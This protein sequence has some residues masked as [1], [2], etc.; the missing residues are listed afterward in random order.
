MPNRVASA[1]LLLSLFAGCN[2]E[3]DWLPFMTGVDKWRGLWRTPTDEHAPTGSLNQAQNVALERS[4]VLQ[5]RRGFDWMSFTQGLGGTINTLQFYQGSLIAHYGTNSIARWTGSAWSTYSGTYDPPDVGGRA[6]F[7]EAED[8]LF[9]LSSLGMY[10]LDTPTGT[11]RLTGMPEGLQGVATLRR[12]SNESG[13][14]TSANGQW[15]YRIVWGH[16][17]ANRRLQLGPPSGRFVL[18]VPANVTATTG[19]ISKTSG[20]AVVTVI[21]TT[22]GF[23]TGEYVDVT[24]GGA[25]T[26]FAAGR[27]S[28]TVVSATSFTYNDG[29]ASGFSGNPVNSITYGFSSR[30][31]DIA[32]PI[33]SGV[34]VDDFVQ[35]YRSAKSAD[36]NSEPSDNLA[37]V[38]EGSPTN[39]EIA[40]GTMTVTDRAYDELR[41]PVLYTS[42]GKLTDAKYRPPKARDAVLFR[43][44]VLM[45]NVA[46][47]R[48][49]ELRLLTAGAALSFQIADQ[50]IFADHPDDLTS[51]TWSVPIA[52]ASTED[53]AAGEFKVYSTGSVAQNI[54]D[55]AKSIVRAINGSTTNDELYAAYVSTD[56]EAP[57]RI[58][59]Y[60][61][62]P[63]IGPFCAF[64]I[65]GGGVQV[66]DTLA[67]RVSSVVLMSN[68]ARSGSTVTV[69][70]AGDHYFAVGQQIELARSSNTTNF[71]NGLKTV[72]T[73]PSSTQFT[74]T[75][76]GVTVGAAANTG[77]FFDQ[78]P[79][80]FQSNESDASAGF[81][82]GDPDEPWSVPPTQFKDL[83]IGTI[84][85]AHATRDYVLVMTD[86]GWHRLLGDGI[87]WSVDEYDLQLNLKAAKTAVAG[88]RGI[89]AL[90]NQGVV[91]AGDSARLISKPIEADLRAL[92]VAATTSV[93]N[94]YAFAVADNTRQRVFFFFPDSSGDTSGVL[95]YVYYANTGD[96]TGPHVWD[97]VTGGFRHGLMEPDSDTL[98]LGA[99]AYVASERRAETLADQT[100]PVY[101]GLVSSTV[102]TLA[103]A[104]ITW[105]AAPA[106]PERYF[107]P[108]ARIYNSTTATTGT[109]ASFAAATNT[110]TL[111]S[112]TGF[113]VGNTV[114]A[115]DISIAS[116]VEPIDI[117][118][119]K[120]G[121]QKLWQLG[122][123]HFDDSRFASV[124]LKW[125]T[126]LS[127][128]Y[129]DAT[130][131]APPGGA[132]AHR[133]EIDFWVARSWMR[134]ARIRW[135]MEH[136]T[137]RETFAL[138]GFNLEGEVES[139]R[140][141]R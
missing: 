109:V 123:L 115:R 25:E 31:A 105:T 8:S 95:A 82:W 137:A 122:S 20:T 92:E 3:P 141:T 94:A 114:Q 136:D 70:T 108:G 90:T 71:P 112:A 130:L 103:G 23:A 53:V 128:T 97:G 69:N 113:S 34:T 116:K 73:V 52:A 61:R 37:Q 57:G 50:L 28:V 47:I 59:I 101:P 81:M 62:T 17:N 72:A 118:G 96:W 24:L 83:G 56:I 13:G 124:D 79:G 125:W 5:P 33:P 44:A 4:G 139:K 89:Y 74:Y 68:I 18:A 21:N 43:D 80:L 11:W 140:S 91:E 85:R 29:G 121:A 26:N 87:N 126:D 133:T 76:S 36:A 7:F 42:L 65:V 129:S 58:R 106:N 100:D 22:H 60:A 16:T 19:N 67:P 51:L 132:G 102:A 30:N 41:A 78:D 127:P 107:F 138:Q 111:E 63:A 48:A 1:L 119:G 35:V 134:G 15:A 55:T 131:M 10:E 45:F 39:L 12:T 40:A 54:A 46:G 88:P 135:L 93:L 110:I 49:L 66:G 104:A 75:E 27:F 2:N 14:F 32:I 77:W 9:F 98:Y 6:H 117:D 99:G 84:Q 38:W 120:P 64:T 86:R